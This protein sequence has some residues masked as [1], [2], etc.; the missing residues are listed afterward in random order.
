M[1][2]PVGRNSPGV[3]TRETLQ[4]SR[5]LA[6]TG[7]SQ[8]QAQV[9]RAAGVADL[10]LAWK[11]DRVGHN[12]GSYGLH[13][14]LREMA[15]FGYLYL[16]GGRWEDRTLVPHEYVE[17]STRTQNEG[18]RPMGALPGPP[19][20][21]ALLWWKSQNNPSQFS[22]DGFCGQQIMVLPEA[23]MVIAMATSTRHCPWM[24][25]YRIFIPAIR[26][27]GTPTVAT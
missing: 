23:D 15:K 4:A 26:D 5:R 2:S 14:T 16:N 13:L 12:M 25:P 19:N 9:A 22:A 11:A 6:P 20:P 21:Y 17:E 1:A 10:R 3:C 18:G 27:G 8:H 7:R 24:T